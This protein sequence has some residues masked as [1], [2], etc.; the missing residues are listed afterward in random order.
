MMMSLAFPYAVALSAAAILL[1]GWAVLW[2]RRRQILDRPNARSSHV[3][4]TPR[5]GGVVLVP[6]LLGGWLV[7]LLAG[8]P[9]PFGMTGTTVLVFLST[10]GLAAVSWLD[11]LR[12]LPPLPRFAAQAVAVTVTVFSLP[13]DAL[14]FQG[15]A[16]AWLDHTLAALAWLW[17][18][19][20]YNFMDGIDGITGVE[21]SSIGGG[22]ALLALTG[23]APAALAA[24]GLALMAVALGF[25]VWN[26][27]P[28]R[29][30][31][32]DVGSI[33]LGYVIGFLLIVLAAN[34]ALAAAL[35]L[36]L[37]YVVDATT[38][39]VR[40][41]ARGEKPWEAHRSHFYQR[42]VGGGQS[43]ARIS[44]AIGLANI[45]LIGCALIA[46]SGWPL[47]ALAGALAL[48]CLLCAAFGHRRQP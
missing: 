27:H 22:L 31:M 3:L 47:G 17:F 46:A 24:P 18:I 25:L 29:L 30:F 48:V 21:T 15:V 44:G 4:P 34:D 37:Y 9:V 40:R 32:G 11:D 28:A 2:L 8:G 23:L 20:L 6:L 10:A 7:S 45:G 14:I 38:T 35:I 5:G 43:H 36:P 42:A 19:N 26:W 13:G 12:P 16:P 33:P 39:L 41:M 1:T